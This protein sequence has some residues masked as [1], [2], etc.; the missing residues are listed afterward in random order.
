MT[1]ETIT[2]TDDG[3]L[4]TSE[5]FAS[6]KKL[7]S[8]YSSYPNEELDKFC[9]KPKKPTTRMFLKQVEPDEATLGKSFNEAVNA[10]SM[11]LR[12]RILMEIAYFKETGNHLDEKGWTITSTLASDDDAFYADW[13]PGGRRF[14]V[15]GYYRSYAGPAGGPR[16]CLTKNPITKP[17]SSVSLPET[18]EINGIMYKQV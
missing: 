7:F 17:S 14:G 6:A 15:G 10:D 3:K 16:Q 12:E 1:S 13:R 4:K 8:V 2:I 5:L 18:L 11:T 9:P